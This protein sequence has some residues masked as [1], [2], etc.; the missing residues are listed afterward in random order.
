[1]I[2]AP[3]RLEWELRK[4][5]QAL[6]NAPAGDDKY[7]FAAV[8]VIGF[9]IGL[10]F[11]DPDVKKFLR[12]PANGAPLFEFYCRVLLVGE[13]IFVL[14]NSLA[15]PEVCRRLKRDLRSGFFEA[16]GCRV[17][18]DNGFE[19]LV[20]DANR[21]NRKRQDD[22]DFQAVRN[23]ETINV[24]VTALTAPSFS[25]KTLLNALHAKRRQLPRG[26]PAVILCVWPDGWWWPADEIRPRIER[27]ERRFFGE[28][29]K[30]DKINAVL[31]IG[32]DP[33]VWG[34]NVQGTGSAP[35]LQFPIFNRKSAFQLDLGFLAGSI[36]NTPELRTALKLGNDLDLL[37]RTF[38]NSEFYR[39]VDQT[40]GHP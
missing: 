21:P 10:N 38:R 24:E 15:F 12:S 39:W 5:I 13:T 2:T 40:L 22:F 28:V 11:N 27:I 3:D 4:T 14:R 36:K 19:L 18:Y 8:L 1:M 16:H 9:Y 35:V 25:E 6:P 33:I 31:F 26:N 17:F 7:A 34:G 29:D 30:T 37:R 32:Q 20:A 23:K